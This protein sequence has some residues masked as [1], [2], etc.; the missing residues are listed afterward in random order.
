M[1]PT[2]RAEKVVLSGPAMIHAARWI[3]PGTPT[4]DIRNAYALF[5]KGV[6]LDSVPAAAPTLI[7]A[8]QSYRLYINGHYICRGP[9]RGH[10]RWWPY[11]EVDLAPWLRPG[12]NIIAVQAHNPGFGTF[13]YRFEGW[14]GFLFMA[15]WD[16]LEIITD[17]TWKCRMQEGIKRDTVPSTVQLFA[18]EHVDARREADDWMQPGFDDSCWGNPVG[19][20]AWNALP[21]YSLE[22]RGLPLL[23]ERPVW[24]R[25]VL[26]TL[27][28]KS[29][30]DWKT[31]R[32]VV[33][34]ARAEPPWHRPL[35]E[36]AGSLLPGLLMEA[37]DQDAFSSVLL[38]FGHTVVGTLRL[39]ITGAKGGEA[40]DAIFSETIIV[41]EKGVA[42]N[43]D[44]VGG[45]HVS[46]GS[47]LI[48]REG[49]TDH[50]FY[51]PYGFRYLALRLRGA[52]SGLVVE[53]SLIHIG[54]PLGDA[55]RFES[56]DPELNRIWKACVL[57]QRVCSLDAY[58]DTPWREQAQWW[59][60]A[61]V[62]AW[63]TFHLV[64]DARL[65][66][67][68]IRSIA[69]QTTPDGLTYGHAPTIA[70]HCVLPDFT[71]IWVLTLWDHYWQ[72]GSLE[73]FL[74]HQDVLR[75]ALDYFQAHTDPATGLVKHDPRYWL[76]LD[77]S[78][79]D[80][81]GQPALLSLW[82]LLALDKTAELYR[83]AGQP[84]E[85]A[86]LEA[87]A[88]RVRASLAHLVNDQGLFGDGFSARGTRITQA[89]VHTQTLA[90]MTGLTAPSGVLLEKSLLPFIRG[91]VTPPAKPSV[92]W[93]T[94]VFSVL[95]AHGHGEAVVRYVRAH[96]GR[97]ADH[98]TTW[99][100]LKEYGGTQSHSHAWSAHPLYHFM[101]IIGGIR[102]KAP[103]WREIEFRPL[104]LGEK[105]EVA[106]PT[107][108]GMVRAIWRR[109]H[110]G[111]EVE[112]QLPEGITARI[113]LPGVDEVCTGGVRRWSL[114]TAGLPPE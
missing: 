30:A 58:V 61:R 111:C 73:A 109:S 40:V 1:H 51:H 71:L 42:L 7:T 99:S 59:G 64:D 32:N 50:T 79:L 78:A 84:E 17:K 16:A 100:Q 87:W 44:P 18:Q 67:R 113:K 2:D 93:L 114:P 5:R 6:W 19:D 4:F 91:E 112:L 62:Q 82:L 55:G 38:D 92:Y 48:C 29:A 80:K 24:P 69:R 27:R 96:W 14:A 88:V 10:Q 45:N 53:P 101:Q 86:K 9:A 75:R 36:D 31:A 41:D 54:Y 35:S 25:C 43:L 49:A 104:F 97:M 77:W 66:L 56:S 46:L 68:G 89:S 52:T 12:R 8:D 22:P 110:A 11:D 21:W 95:D 20:A 81:E 39:K 74:E 26:A 102:Q 34:V 106:V 3:W 103:A 108:Q 107:P 47:R 37:S 57:T 28:G 13:Q 90:M 72:T 94:Y 70:H 105:A 60:D 98:G 63:N 83:L 15:R 85:A 65:L 76:F 23:E 33:E